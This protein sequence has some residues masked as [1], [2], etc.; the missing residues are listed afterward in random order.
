MKSKI[1]WNNRVGPRGWLRNGDPTGDPNTAPRCGA[2]TRAGGQCKVPGMR[3]G[4]CRMHGGA[5]TGPR[6]A[7]GLA[8]SKRSRWRH[9]LYSAEAKAEWKFVRDLARKCLD[10][11]SQLG[12]K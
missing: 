10:L 6:T 3:N 7:E 12:L 4:R 11:L 9:G 2:K 8:C 5:S 1:D